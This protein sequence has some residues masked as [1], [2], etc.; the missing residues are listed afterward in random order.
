M[1]S[2][3]EYFTIK[4]TVQKNVDSYVCIRTDTEI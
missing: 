4:Y 3:A 1:V 2:L